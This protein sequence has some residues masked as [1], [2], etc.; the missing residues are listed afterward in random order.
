M[1][2]SRN[3]KTAANFD[4]FCSPVVVFNRRVREFSHVTVIELKLF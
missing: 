3:E 1:S 2:S 4:G